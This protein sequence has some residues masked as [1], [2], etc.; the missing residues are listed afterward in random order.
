MPNAAPLAAGAIA[1]QLSLTHPDSRIRRLTAA[2]DAFCRALFRAHR[3]AEF[4]PL[5]LGEAALV[6]MLDQ[7]FQAQRVAYDRRFPGAEPFIIEHAG[8]DVGRLIVTLDQ[9]PASPDGAVPQPQAT[10]HLVDITIAAAA[11]NRGIGSD[12][13]ASLVRAG[14]G[15]GATRFTLFVLQTNEAALRLYQRLGFVA[16]A[17]AGHIRMVRRLP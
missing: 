3:G 4:A 16:A 6:S 8:A 2:D 17:D 7:Q 14:H 10:L 12:V 13:M 5:G 11:R 1:G 15:L 9:S